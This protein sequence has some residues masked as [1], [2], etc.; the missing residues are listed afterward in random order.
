MDNIKNDK[1]EKETEE[2]VSEM[3]KKNIEK[4]LLD[5]EGGTPS[6]SLGKKWREVLAGGTGKNE[7]SKKH[8]SERR[9]PGSVYNDLKELQR[10]DKLHPQE[11]REA[12]VKK[13]REESQR[14]ADQATGEAS[15][16]IK[17]YKTR[18]AMKVAGKQISA[19]AYEISQAMAKETNKGGIQAVVPIVMTYLIA[20]LK[21]LI[22]FT[23]VG[24]IL[25]ILT[26][27]ICGAIIALFW[28]QVSGGWKGGY[29]R[30]KLIKKIIIKI[31]LAAFIET[32]PGPNI[33]PTFI[34]MNLWSHLDFSRS[35]KKAK[36]DRKKFENDLATKKK[37]NWKIGK[38]YIEN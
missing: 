20:L 24:A 35:I 33:I 26:G 11:N 23:G 29:I 13:I 9:K 14:R 1:T 2:K 8:S 16:Q 37:V 27:I 4:L 10:Q 21:D 32:L 28:V 34:V 6:E 7:A 3:L 17:D 5:K 30:R 25:G 12:Q 38:N 18:V 15:K 19:V 31:G 36:S 22:D